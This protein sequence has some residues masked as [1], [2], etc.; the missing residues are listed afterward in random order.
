MLVIMKRPLQRLHVAAWHIPKPRSSDGRYYLE[1]HAAQTSRLLYTKVDHNCFK[2]AD[3]YGP[4]AFQLYIILGVDW[5]PGLVG[6][7]EL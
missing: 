1:S 5:A 6:E 7:V 3:D 4:L 2:I